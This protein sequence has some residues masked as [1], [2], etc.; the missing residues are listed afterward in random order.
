MAHLIEIMN[1]TLLLIFGTIASVSFAGYEKTTKNRK[2]IAI[3]VLVILGLQLI[4][5]YFA[6]L[7]V[8]ARL[9]PLITHLPSVVFIVRYLKKP[10]P[11]AI[12]S[13][14]T[15]YLCCQP[16][17][18]LGLV[19][20]AFF[21]STVAFSIGYSIGLL[22]MLYLI[23]RYIASPV[24]QVMSYS[25]SALYN[26]GSFP[27]IYYL[28]D[29][30]TT[31]Y[32]EFLYSGAKIVVEFF[33]SVISMFYIVFIIVYSNEMQKRNKLELNN[34]MLEAQSERAKKE[35][36]AL[37]QVQN[38]TAIYR[39]D[40]RHHLSLLLGF[41]ENGEEEAAIDYIRRAQVDI[42]GIVPVRYCENNMINLI[43]SAFVVKAN[44]RGVSF[45]IDAVLPD[46]LPFSDTE[47]CTLLSNAL[48]NAVEAA[49]KKTGCGQNDCSGSDQD[50]CSG[51]AEG[52][53]T[54]NVHL[55]CKIHKGN[56]LILIENTYAGMVQ[57]K[58][59][60]PQTKREGHGFG[61]KS[62]VMLVDR[63]KGY[64]SFSSSDGLFTL[65]IVLPMQ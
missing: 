64:Y 4:S 43:L 28:F 52:E 10:L 23:K 50:D 16:P 7:L 59:G 6:G 17:N 33:P 53:G 26:F 30:S 3:L 58:N 46:T 38:Q 8:T 60:L 57:I 22:I 35:I 42:D 47:L 15:A 24:N 48:E 1:Y 61:T 62:I 2:V 14:L 65:K 5:Y 41:L 44:Q 20:Q 45:S 32:T 40:M 54:G 36:Y 63:Y 29:Y 31:I 11:I 55:N 34:A 56:L 12:V 51:C 19:M 49:A 25:R 18:W 37:Q 9:Y 21:D 13:V 27:L 39:H